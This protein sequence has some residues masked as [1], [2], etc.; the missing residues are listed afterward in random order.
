VLWEE[1]IDVGSL[2]VLI[3]GS[4]G[5]CCDQWSSVCEWT[6]EV[7]TREYMQQLQGGQASL[8]DLVLLSCDCVQLRFSMS[9][10]W[11]E[12]IVTSLKN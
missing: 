9:L 1:R 11:W 6:I 12:L 2:G 4:V 10:F 8:V 5:C 7:K 3:V